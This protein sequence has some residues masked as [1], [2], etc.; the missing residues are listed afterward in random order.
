MLVVVVIFFSR[1]ELLRAWKLLSQV[2]LW[3]LLLIIPVQFFS[4][5]AVGA[6]IFSYLK[7]KGPINA[8]SL[9]MAKMALELNF[10]NHI[11]PSGGVSGASYMTW[12]LG[13]VGVSAARATLAQ[14]VRFAVTFGGFLILLV[15]AVIAITLDGHITRFMLMVSSSLAA[16]ILFVS[17]IGVYLI[18]SKAR[19][20]ASA[21]F[22]A[23]YINLFW[24][25]IL[26]RP[27]YLLGEDRVFSFFE[28]FHHDFGEIAHEPRILLRPLLWGILFT[29]ADVLMFWIAFWALGT[30][31]NPAPLLIAYGGAVI[32]G[33][34]FITPGGAGGFEVIM[35]AVLTAAGIGQG[36]SVAAILLTRVLLI[37]GTIITGYVFYQKALNSY[38][39]NTSTR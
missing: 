28:A 24:M 8:S 19:L 27:K 37:L 5:Y 34:L 21:R 12:R 38:G 29:V 33:M 4:Y 39:K 32:A 9:E 15:F 23:K 10:V 1:H 17:L 3:V 20:H 7:Q 31:I 36:E 13:H 18:A 30:P 14:V 25:R 11:L 26:R 2:N 22:I 35:I 6:M 16:S